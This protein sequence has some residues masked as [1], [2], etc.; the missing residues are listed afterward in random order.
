MEG[1]KDDKKSGR[2]RLEVLKRQETIRKDVAG[3][4]GG[5]GTRVGKKSPLLK[6]GGNKRQRADKRV[7]RGLRRTERSQMELEGGAEDKSTD[8]EVGGGQMNS[9]R[10]KK[11]REEVS[12]MRTDGVG[13][14]P[15]KESGHFSGDGT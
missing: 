13:Q 12:Y 6:V 2:G 1:G 15:E 14:A 8:K 11:F 9:E 10:A 4:P 5:G 7:R 3:R